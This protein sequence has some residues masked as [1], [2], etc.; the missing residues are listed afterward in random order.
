[1]KLLKRVQLIVAHKKFHQFKQIWPKYIHPFT[2][3]H[4]NGPL[5]SLAFLSKS[6]IANHKNEI[7]MMKEWKETKWTFYKYF[8]FNYYDAIIF[9]LN[10]IKGNIK[11]T[12]YYGKKRRKI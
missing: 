4:S 9:T 12:A 11:N 5:P 3:I 10:R 6:L 1:M 2:N 8:V 7:G